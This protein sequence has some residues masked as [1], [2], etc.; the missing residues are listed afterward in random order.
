MVE[1]FRR[2]DGRKRAQSQVLDPS[3]RERF[4]DRHIVY[5]C[6]TRGQARDRQTQLPVVV[7]VAHSGCYSLLLT[8]SDATVTGN[9]LPATRQARAAP[10]ARPLTLLGKYYVSTAAA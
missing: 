10:D 2:R 3:K 7:V 6:R 1:S 5:E 9:S 4:R 8:K